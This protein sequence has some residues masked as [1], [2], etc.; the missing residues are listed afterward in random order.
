MWFST[1]H[2]SIVDGGLDHLGYMLDLFD[3]VVVD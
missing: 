3:I 2:E 1:L